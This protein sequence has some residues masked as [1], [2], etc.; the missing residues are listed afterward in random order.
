MAYLANED[1][2]E[3]LI[4]AA[5]DVIAGEGLASATTRKIAERADSSL[6]ALHYCFRGKDDLLAAVADRIRSTLEDSFADVDPAEGFEATVRTTI[7]S[8]WQWIRGN[9]GLHM[10]IAELV[11]W[12]IRRGKPGKRLYAR[13]NSSFGGDL[14]RQTL[15]DA[16][17]TDGL[18]SAVPID[19][20]ARFVLHRFDGLTFEY[21][22][23]ADAKACQ[24]QT[25]LLADA[26]LAL[27][28]GV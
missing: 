27:A 26:I 18:E 1:R 5:I 7:D 4:D 12:E 20:L 14:L 22:E 17:A 11:V 23:S 6:G 10:A 25:E 24:R 2:R 16:A 28:R 21:A 13:L 19:E 9:P 15:E 8:Y 3:L